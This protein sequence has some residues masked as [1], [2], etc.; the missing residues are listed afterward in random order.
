M[1]NV[2]EI[3]QA[4]SSGHAVT[5]GTITYRFDHEGDLLY[6]YKGRRGSGFSTGGVSLYPDFSQPYN[7]YKVDDF[8]LVLD[9]NLPSWD[10]LEFRANFT[11]TGKTIIKRDQIGRFTEDDLVFIKIMKTIAE[12]KKKRVRRF[13]RKGKE[14]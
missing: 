4:L 5:N 10:V 8:E 14:L 13:C 2:S 6:Q 11:K 9:P 7:F 1:E 3:W 12:A